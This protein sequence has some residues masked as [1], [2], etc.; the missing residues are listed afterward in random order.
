VEVKPGDA[1]RERVD[2]K[3]AQRLGSETDGVENV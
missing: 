3:V 2:A 1:D